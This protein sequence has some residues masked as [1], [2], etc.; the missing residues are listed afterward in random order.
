MT[1]RRTIRVLLHAGLGNQMFMY[2]AGRALALR[3]D[4][5]LVL[6]IS[7]FRR[8]HV[9]HRTFGL[10][11]FPIQARIVA[12]GPVLRRVPER[13]S[14]KIERMIRKS[15]RWRTVFGII[16]ERH[17]AGPSILAPPDR[18][19]LYVD[20]YWQ[21]ERYFA[22]HAQVVRSELTPPRPKEGPITTDL[23]LIE[24]ASLPVA[25]GVRFYQ[26]VP[27][28][29]V[30]RPAILSAYRR[31]LLAH[32]ERHPEAA[33]FVF[34]EEPQSFADA[35]CLGVPFRVVGD[36]VRNGDPVYVMSRCRHFFLGFSSYHWWGTWLADHPR[37]EV[38]YLPLDRW[39]PPDY[40]PGDWRVVSTC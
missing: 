38:H 32:R 17:P 3:L 21:S 30:D 11:G 24:S 29:V 7:R 39:S 36:G 10:G 16:D 12:E 37:R 14:S 34:T 19:T 20:G 4:A 26:D 9:Y 40:T 25:V 6:D 2:A 1:R 31:V 5:D 28:A 18:R 15:T 13:V 35:E 23:G 33:Y 22:D 8:D 27:G